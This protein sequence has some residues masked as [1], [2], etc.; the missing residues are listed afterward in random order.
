MLIFLHSSAK[1][2]VSRDSDA[3]KIFWTF[4]WILDF[5]KTKTGIKYGIVFGS[6]IRQ[7]VLSRSRWYLKAAL[8][9]SLGSDFLFLFWN[10]ISLA[11]Y[12][13]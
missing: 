10:K 3:V 13:S 6:K 8:E 5:S 9:D 4:P 12:D 1:T 7:Y 11:N 2:Q